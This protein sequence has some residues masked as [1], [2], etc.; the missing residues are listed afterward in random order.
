MPR[1]RDLLVTFMRREMDELFGDWSEAG[2]WAG[3]QA[4]FSPHV[5]VYYC[6]KP[7]KAVVKVDLAGVSLDNVSLEIVGRELVIRGER[8]VQESEGRVYQQVEIEAGPFRRVVELSADVVAEEARATYE[9]GVLRVELPLR[10][11]RR[12]SRRVPIDT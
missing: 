8:P 5:D 12:G 10:P 1:D 3:P 11:S 6:G 2:R 9:D 7:P 4:G